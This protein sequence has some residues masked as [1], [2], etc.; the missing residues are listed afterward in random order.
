MMP[1]RGQI[2]PVAERMTADPIDKPVAVARLGGDESLF[3]DFARSVVDESPGMLHEIRHSLAGG[4]I[5]EAHRMAHGLKGMLATLEARPATAAA[6]EVERLTKVG[7]MTAA[8]VQT[9]RL[10][11]ELDRLIAALAGL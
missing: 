4:R 11:V 9:D 7:D 10:A 2:S 1:G 3:I 8:A 5:D 6:A